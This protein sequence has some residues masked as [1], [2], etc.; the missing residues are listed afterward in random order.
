MKRSTK[1]PAALWTKAYPDQV[2]RRTA[3]NTAGCAHR[4]DVEKLRQTVYAGIREMFLRGNRACAG[5]YYVAKTMQPSRAVDVH[6]QRGRE[7]LLLFDVRYFIPL[8]RRCHEFVEAN[9]EKAREFGLEAER[10]YWGRQE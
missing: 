10:G 9:K 7:G 1:Q 4:S 6:H 3:A 2:R 5:C 8:C